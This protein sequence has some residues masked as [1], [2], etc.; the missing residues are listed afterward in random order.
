MKGRLYSILI[1]DDRTFDFYEETN[2]HGAVG[3]SIRNLG[4][5]VLVID[6]TTQEEILPGEY[7]L[8]ENDCALVNRDFRLRFLKEKGKQNKAVV[9]YIVPVE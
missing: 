7:F 9:R 1:T 8:I 6:D 2:C 4:D 5:S 3:I